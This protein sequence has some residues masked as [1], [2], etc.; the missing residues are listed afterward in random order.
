MK[1]RKLVRYGKTQW[2]VDLGLQNGRRSR[3]FFETEAK[4]KVFINAKKT[5]LDRFGTAFLNLTHEDR[6]EFLTAQKR[7]KE[8]GASLTE[9]VNLY[10]KRHHHSS[11]KSLK[12]AVEE[13]LKTK[14][15]S[16]RRPR[17][18]VQLK[19]TLGSLSAAL[20]ESRVSDIMAADIE[21]WLSS[22]PLA[23][24]TK[25]SYLTDVATFFKFA[26]KRRWCDANPCDEMEPITLETKPPGILTVEQSEQLMRTAEA[27]DR[28]LCPWLALALFC[29]IRPS[30]LQKITR[31]DVHADRGFVEIL[32]ETAK[33]RRRRLVTLP[34]NAKQWLELS[35]DLPPI[36]LKR[37][38]ERL[39]QLSGIRPW[40]HDAMRH[41]AASY[42]LAQNKDAPRTA[43]NLGHSPDIL[44][45]HYR[46]VVTPE[47]AE[48]FFN[49]CPSPVS[50]AVTTQAA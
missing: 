46:E 31:T 20:P 15:D 39:K 22:R 34:E 49:I 42:Q 44:F 21:T 8:V 18:L 32:G 19:S 36:N 4:A 43:L 25:K 27:H 23:L 45:R 7:L 6:I 1:M 26:L 35:G 28:G 5:E 48:R 41:S 16:G 33:T 11:K 37:R 30:E 47:D 24:A 40:P 2:L 29:G 13:C 12:E 50:L 9:V 17:Y 38:T 3:K 14:K 10:I